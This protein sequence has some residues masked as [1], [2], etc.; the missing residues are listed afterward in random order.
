MAKIIV[1]G[2]VDNRLPESVRD[3]LNYQKLKGKYFL[4]NAPAPSLNYKDQELTLTKV[5]AAKGVSEVWLIDHLDCAGFALAQESDDLQ[6]HQRHL[7]EART[8]LIE[9]FGFDTVRT[10]I[11][12]PNGDE[13]WEIEEQT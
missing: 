2:C 5:A 9:N 12:K 8:D 1:V 11:A 3:F 6:N 7:S 13:K 10:F 4:A